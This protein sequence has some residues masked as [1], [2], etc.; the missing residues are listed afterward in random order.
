MA[1]NAQ[2]SV[3]C[4]LSVYKQLADTFAVVRPEHSEPAEQCAK[5]D[6]GSIAV[7][8]FSSQI[9]AYIETAHPF[10]YLCHV[11]FH[12]TVIRIPIPRYLNDQLADP[13]SSYSET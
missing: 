5:R 4:F 12:C 3:S 2:N 10:Q 9:N 13:I 6:C 11:Q 7:Q 1:Q 8:L